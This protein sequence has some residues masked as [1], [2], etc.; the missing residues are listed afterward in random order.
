MAFQYIKAQLYPISNPPVVVG[1]D[2]RR[3]VPVY[4][5]NKTDE[6]NFTGWSAKAHVRNKI[7]GEIIATFDSEASPATIEFDG[8]KMYLIKPKEETI[9]VVP[10]SY[11]WDCEFVDTDGYERTLI[12]ESLFEVVY[13]QTRPTS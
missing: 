13:H 5:K 4:Q 8:G 7:T 2:W 9:D 12:L 11:V 3:L 6:F 1:D 10:D